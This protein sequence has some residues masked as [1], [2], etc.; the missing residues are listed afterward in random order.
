[1]SAELQKA[2]DDLA[3]EELRTKRLNAAAP[4]LLKCLKEMRDVNAAWMRAAQD[5]MPELFDL[6]DAELEKIGVKNGFG[7]RA[8]AAIRLAETGK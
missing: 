4:Q 6:F 2:I 3:A 1:M 8:Q 7:V 5:A